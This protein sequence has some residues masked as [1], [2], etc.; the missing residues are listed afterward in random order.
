MKALNM[1]DKSHVRKSSLQKNTQLIMV[2]I[3]V[4]Q[5]YQLLIIKVFWRRRKVTWT[6]A[7][8]S[9][10]TGPCLQFSTRVDNAVTTTSPCWIQIQTST[11]DAI[12][13]DETSLALSSHP[14]SWCR[15]CEQCRKV[16]C[17]NCYL[18]TLQNHTVILGTQQSETIG[19]QAIPQEHNLAE[20]IP[21]TFL[22]NVIG[23]SVL[24]ASEFT[25]N[26]VSNIN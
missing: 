9:A 24:V 18:N 17:Y 13:L 11:C 7:I 21:K 15:T 1:S 20:K 12:E 5:T 14:F 19:N 2:S 16:W 22:S 26:Q 4:V 8:Y 25:G 3:R 6:G 10:Y 23:I